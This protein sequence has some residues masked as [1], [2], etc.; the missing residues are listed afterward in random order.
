MQRAATQ[1]FILKRVKLA[2]L[3]H[4]CCACIARMEE[5]VCIRCL[6]Q[7]ENPACALA[8]QHKAAFTGYREWAMLTG[9]VAALPIIADGT[10]VCAHSALHTQSFQL[11]A[12]A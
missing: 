4:L 7:F 3:Q 5:V 9:C 11:S 10:F 6:N 1:V 2:H 12:T 8:G